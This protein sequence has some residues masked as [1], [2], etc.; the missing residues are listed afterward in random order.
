MR[1]D[2][3]G[4]DRDTRPGIAPQYYRPTVCL[5]VMSL[6]TSSCGYN[7]GERRATRCA[8]IHGA[9]G[10]TERAREKFTTPLSAV[11]SARRLMREGHGGCPRLTPTSC[12]DA[13]PHCEQGHP[14]GRTREEKRLN[15]FKIRAMRCPYADPL[16]ASRPWP[17]C[18][19][20]RVGSY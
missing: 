6:M 4:Q 11:R 19:G 2:N 5:E 12:T 7:R 9:R 15:R 17:R 10:D 13:A 1:G 16:F 18:Y 8:I 14:G 20:I 3:I